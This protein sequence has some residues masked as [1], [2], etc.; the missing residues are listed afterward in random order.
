MT[1]AQA[2]LFGAML[3]LGPSMIVMAFLLGGMGHEDDLNI[4]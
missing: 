3:V 2:I 4:D 1:T